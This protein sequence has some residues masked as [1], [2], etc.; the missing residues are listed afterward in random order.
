MLMFMIYISLNHN[1]LRLIK[2]KSSANYL[3]FNNKFSLTRYT[4]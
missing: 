4:L 1:K 3:Y 2:E